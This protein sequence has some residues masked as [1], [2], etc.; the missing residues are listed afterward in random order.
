[1]RRVRLDRT[2]R[3]S[4]V[5]LLDPASFNL[6]QLSTTLL[7]RSVGKEEKGKKEGEII[8]RNNSKKTVDTEDR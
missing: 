4:K 2:I 3:S 6:L 8:R 7:V 5:C 1:M